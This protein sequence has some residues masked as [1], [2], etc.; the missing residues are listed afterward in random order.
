MI[1]GTAQGILLVVIRRID[2]VLRTVKFPVVLVPG[3]KRNILSSLV[4]AP[5]RCQNNHRKQW[6]IPW[7]W[8]I[9]CLVDTI[10]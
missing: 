1:L 2:D 5:K 8:T 6:L 4:A 7:L 9:K 3:L 10:E